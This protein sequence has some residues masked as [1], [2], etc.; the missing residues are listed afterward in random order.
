MIGGGRA[1]ETHFSVGGFAGIGLHASLSPMLHTQMLKLTLAVGKVLRG[2]DT[3]TLIWFLCRMG[4]CYSISYILLNR[5]KQTKNVSRP[6]YLALC[7]QPH[8]KTAHFYFWLNM[9]LLDLTQGWRAR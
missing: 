9:A 5:Q 1:A 8:N 6:P 3:D 4:A 7:S 2:G